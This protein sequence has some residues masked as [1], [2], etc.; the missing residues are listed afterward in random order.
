MLKIRHKKSVKL[1]PFPAIVGI[2]R[3]LLKREIRQ[4]HAYKRE[5]LTFSSFFYLQSANFTIAKNKA[6][7]L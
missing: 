5:H 6:K 1:K 3:N 2:C 4:V 7:C